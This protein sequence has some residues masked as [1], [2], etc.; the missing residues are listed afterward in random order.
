MAKIATS[1]LHN[2]EHTKAGAKIFAAVPVSFT[3]QQ[4]ECGARCKIARATATLS[5]FART[6]ST[7]SW[8]TGSTFIQSLASQICHFSAQNWELNGLGIDLGWEK[9]GLGDRKR[10][11]RPKDVLGH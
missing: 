11:E 2:G 9:G 7:T 4:L 5:I 1:R 6:P 8:K 10:V 3:L